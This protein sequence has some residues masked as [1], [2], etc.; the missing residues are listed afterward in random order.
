MLFK[1]K[2]DI[3]FDFFED[4]SLELEIENYRQKMKKKVVHSDRFNYKS[5][6]GL[7]VELTNDIAE[8]N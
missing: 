8:F 5:G 1:M 6:K 2:N 7:F 4:L 3:E